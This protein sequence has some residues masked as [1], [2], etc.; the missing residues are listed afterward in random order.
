MLYLGLLCLALVALLA[1]EKR[2]YAVRERE[3]AVERQ[4][5]LNRIQ[6]PQAAPYMEEDAEVQHVPFE[7]DEAFEAAREEA[8]LN[9]AE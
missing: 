7:D 8:L 6:A 5:L 9:G 4:S 2:Q 1:Y 3:F